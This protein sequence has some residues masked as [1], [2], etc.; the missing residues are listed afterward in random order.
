MT[1]LAPLP[2]VE[3]YR[4]DAVSIEDGAGL[5]DAITAAWLESAT[6]LERAAMTRG[7]ER[8]RLLSG[9]L[10]QH[11]V[12]T[13]PASQ[14][15]TT[16]LVSA[17]MSMASDMEDQALFRM[18]HSVLSTLLIILP[19]SEHLLRGRVI[20]QQGRLARHLGDLAASIRYYKEVEQLATESSL[21]ELNGR[22]WVGLGILAQV[23]GDFPESRRRFKAVIELE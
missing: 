17:V 7:S 23:R 14:I 3:A 8:E 13:F 2:S 9:L 21:A 4:R 16:A 6:R 20:A 5:D 15:S 19:E 11:G 18:A 1:M 10:A 12:V 22:A